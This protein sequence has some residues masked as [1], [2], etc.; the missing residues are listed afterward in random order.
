MSCL[1]WKEG[2][3]RGWGGKEP[4]GAP[5]YPAGVRGAARP[6]PGSCPGLGLQSFTSR[7]LSAAGRVALQGTGGKTSHGTVKSK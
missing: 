1:A 3:T 5:I 2:A 7:R 6:C 4:A